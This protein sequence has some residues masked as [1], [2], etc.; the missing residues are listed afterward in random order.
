MR[1][2][3][4][5]KKKNAAKCVWDMTNRLNL[6]IRKAENL[7]LTVR[8]D[9]DP[10]EMRGSFDYVRSGVTEIIS[11]P[12]HPTR[13]GACVSRVA[14]ERSYRFRKQERA[15]IERELNNFLDL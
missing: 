14:E 4:L 2:N 15:E 6:A 13:T 11:Y 9:A 3:N 10:A 1:D 12:G 7:G 8:I 5:A